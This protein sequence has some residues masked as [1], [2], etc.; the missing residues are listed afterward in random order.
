MTQMQNIGQERLVSL[1]RVVFRLR[2]G[3]HSMGL[4][5]IN[6]STIHN[7]PQ[8]QHVQKTIT[9]DGNTPA[10]DSPKSG[11]TKVAEVV[12]GGMA[13]NSSSVSAGSPSQYDINRLRT[14]VHQHVPI[15]EISQ[16]LHESIATIRKQAAAAGLSL[17]YSSSN[18]STANIDNA[19]PGNSINLKV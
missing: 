4:A 8:K 11:G 12:K 7:V 17:N 16:R 9:S 1:L 10:T 5:P 19:A 3:G 14:L 15:N 2:T 13:V 18:S 6:S